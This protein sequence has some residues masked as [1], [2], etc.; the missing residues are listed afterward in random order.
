MPDAL[1]GLYQQVILDH[2]RARTGEGPLPDAAAEHFER[3]PTCGDEITVRIRLASGSDRIEALAWEG[4]GCSISM[5]SA[6][7]L[8]DLATGRTLAEMGEVTETFRAMMRSKGQG[9]PDEE[10]LGDAV[11]FQGVS[12][13]VM[14]V[15]CAMLSWVALE[16]CST[17]IAA[18]A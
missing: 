13:F 7:V 17:K 4:D 2:S 5:A 6:S 11:V 3:N 8:T 10:V 1:A 14:R 9:E 18:R 16:A 12:K 15:K